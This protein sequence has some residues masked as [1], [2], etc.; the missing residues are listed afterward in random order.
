MRPDSLVASRLALSSSSCLSQPFRRRAHFRCRSR[1]QAIPTWP[2]LA[3]SSSSPFNNSQVRTIRK[4]AAR[5]KPKEGTNSKSSKDESK[6]E[7]EDEE[8]KTLPSPSSA[9]PTTTKEA[10]PKFNLPSE[11]AALSS[12]YSNS[13]QSFHRIQSSGGTLIAIDCEGAP[14]KP[15]QIGF[16]AKTYSA[17][18]PSF[19]KISQANYGI[20]VKENKPDLFLHGVS[21]FCESF[22]Q[23]AE[24]FKERFEAFQRPLLVVFH[25]GL[26]AQDQMILRDHG[27]DMTGWGHPQESNDV[28]V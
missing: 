10:L 15:T 12:Y 5:K 24:A 9:S 23:A 13:R 16:S 22:A 28:T 21:H 4:S 17:A 20:E 27:I 2:P 25:G 19:Y 11:P 8:Q 1:V 6:S 3:S 26:G 18:D 7:A 14:A